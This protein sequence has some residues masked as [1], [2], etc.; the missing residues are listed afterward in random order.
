MLRALL[1]DR[2]KLRYHIEHGVTD[3]YTLTLARADG[4]LGPKLRASA[5]DCAARLAAAAQKQPV[6]PLPPGATACGIRNA[7]GLLDFGG[8]ASETAH[9]IRL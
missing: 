1:I 2:F 5:V 3:G 8:A 4:R 9:G 7:R 6:P